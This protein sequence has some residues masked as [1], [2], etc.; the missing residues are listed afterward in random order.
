[1][2]LQKRITEDLKTSMKAKNALRVEV[3]RMMISALRNREIEKRTKGE[4]ADLIDEEVI[5]VLMRETKKRREAAD[6]YDS[7][8]RPELASKERLEAGIIE[9][10]LPVQMSEE[11][12]IPYVVK[13]IADTGA[14]TVK[15]T[16]KVMAIVVKELKGKADGSKIGKIVKE[17][18]GA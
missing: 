11:E 6:V 2:S 7:G 10:F 4:A 17:K 13:A 3:L 9:E 15:D 16:G 8:G 1:M 5:G 12:I 18:L 14:L